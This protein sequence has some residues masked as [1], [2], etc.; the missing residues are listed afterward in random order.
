MRDGKW[1]L[2]AKHDEPWELYDIDSDR[3]EQHDFAAAEAMRRD[4]MIEQYEKWAKACNVAPWPIN[5]KS[6]AKK[7]AKKK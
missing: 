2:V 1:K 7:P 4:A 6:K 3:S 5:D